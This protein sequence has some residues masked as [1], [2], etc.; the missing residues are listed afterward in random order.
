[1]GK[2]YAIMRD[3]EFVV[4]TILNESPASREEAQAM[5]KKWALLYPGNRYTVEP[6]Q[7]RSQAEQNSFFGKTEARGWR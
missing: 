1:M 2:Y 7:Q 3:G 4:T 6:L 5:C